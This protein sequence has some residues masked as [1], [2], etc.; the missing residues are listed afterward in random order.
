MPLF[1]LLLVDD[2][3]DRAV[4][5]LMLPLSPY[6]APID[7]APLSNDGAILAALYERAPVKP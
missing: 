4:G 6:R 5:E 2:D 7:T 1:L 3:P